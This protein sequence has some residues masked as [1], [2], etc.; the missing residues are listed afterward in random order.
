MVGEIKGMETTIIEVYYTPST[1]TSAEIEI[2]FR[3]SEYDSKPRS[4][5]IVGSAL[6]SKLDVRKALE[7][8]EHL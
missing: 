4:C 6:P 3:T 8:G 5:R 1:F 2:E 7:K